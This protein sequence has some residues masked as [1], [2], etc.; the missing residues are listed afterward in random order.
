MFLESK[1]YDRNFQA[2]QITENLPFTVKCVDNE[3]DLN[4]AISI[5]HAAYARHVPELAKKLE[6]PEPIDTHK[7]VTILL[8]ESKDDARPLGTV[9]IQTNRFGALSLEQSICLPDSLKYRSLA[10]IS[11]LAVDRGTHAT[12][13]KH[14]LFKG[15]YHFWVAHQ[16]EWA[17]VAARSPLDRMYEKLQFIDVF[18][19]GGYVPLAQMGNMMHRIMAFEVGTASERWHAASH[20]L[21]RSVFHTDHPD[22]L[23]KNFK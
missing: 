3:I 23:I 10:H 19:D 12:A 9:R 16:I 11:R 21:T 1:K 22:L 7:G 4:K 18:S 13:V 20:P 14:M 2:I 15:L 6:H 17:I 8:A 5:R